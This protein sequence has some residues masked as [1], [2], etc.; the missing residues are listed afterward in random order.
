[1]LFLE[2]APARGK[3]PATSHRQSARGGIASRF[4]HRGLKPSLSILDAHNAFAVR[5]IYLTRTTHSLCGS[6]TR[7]AQRIR[8]AADILDAH[9]VFA[10]RLLP[11]SGTT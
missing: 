5:L 4:R 3:I 11:L 6:Y 2:G 10:V 8:C 7:R 9:N 1:M